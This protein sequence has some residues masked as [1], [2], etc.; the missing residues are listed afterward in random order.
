MAKPFA[1]KVQAKKGGPGTSLVSGGCHA[2]R[3]DALRHQRALYANMPGAAAELQAIDLELAAEERREQAA[4]L[5][6]LA[7]DA[8]RGRRDREANARLER[9]LAQL[10]ALGATDDGDI[11]KLKQIRALIDKNPARA[12]QLLDAFI[13]GETV[14]PPE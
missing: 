14:E 3:A 12:K 8:M 10:E 5:R 6:D 13:A 1:V 4:G 7:H 2:T 11:A 9:Q